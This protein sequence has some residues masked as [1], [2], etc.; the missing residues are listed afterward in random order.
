MDKTIKALP[1]LACFMLYGAMAHAQSTFNGQI[2]P[3]LSTKDDVEAMLGKPVSQ[4]NATISEY[5]APAGYKTV[6]I[7][8]DQ[9]STV[10]RIGATFPAP[11]PAL[12]RRI[13]THSIAPFS[14][15]LIL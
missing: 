14:S 3:G 2:V 6:R 15:G 5:K 7:Q 9:S 12:L 1:V 13:L 10:M 8:F 11:R 4:V